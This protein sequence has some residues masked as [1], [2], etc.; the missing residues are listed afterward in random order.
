[1]SCYNYHHY[2]HPQAV[3]RKEEVLPL[4]GGNTKNKLPT[5]LS[6]VDKAGET[7]SWL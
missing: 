6:K 1:M 3:A 7:L 5:I 2:H 4:G